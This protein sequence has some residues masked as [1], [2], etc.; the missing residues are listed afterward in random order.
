MPT[1]KL[2][3]SVYEIPDATVKYLHS[4]SLGT[5]DLRGCF[6]NAA[7]LEDAEVKMDGKF[8]KKMNLPKKMKAEVLQFFVDFPDGEVE[9]TA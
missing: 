8:W 6:I 4:I 2:S 7:D 1:H 9:W 3:Y 5:V